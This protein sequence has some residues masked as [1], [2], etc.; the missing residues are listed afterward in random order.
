MTGRYGA[1]VHHHCW[2]CSLT[3]REVFSLNLPAVRSFSVWR[4]HALSGYSSFHPYFK[5]KLV[6]LVGDSKLSVGE[7]IR[8]NACLSVAICLGC[9]SNMTVMTGSSPPPTPAW[10]SS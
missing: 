6:R 10:K 1:V 8:V 3:E 5:N 9:L 4:L 2:H 7:N